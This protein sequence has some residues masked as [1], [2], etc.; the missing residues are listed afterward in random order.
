MPGKRIG[1][2]VVAVVAFAACAPSSTPGGYVLAVYEKE[3][4]TATGEAIARFYEN[5]SGTPPAIDPWAVFAVGS[6]G[7]LSTAETSWSYTAT[8]LGSAIHL[9][10]GNDTITMS[11]TSSGGVEEYSS[12]SIDG[13]TLAPG[14]SWDVE[15]ADPSGTGT[16]VWSGSLVMPS[17]PA[18]S[19]PDGMTAGKVMLPASGALTIAFPAAGAAEAY[20]VFSSDE[21]ERVCRLSPEAG[22]FSVPED[23]LLRL[24]RTGTMEIVLVNVTHETLSGNDIDVQGE[25]HLRAAF[26]RFGV[27]PMDGGDLQS[28]QQSTPPSSEFPTGAPL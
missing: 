25:V 11:L 21:G 4:S 14:E 13:A 6:C 20:V 18:V 23:E 17:V 3:G 24:P 5:V 26:T 16:D 2:C 12:G 10:R 15:F 22:S 8:D 1:L 19:E 28:R 7:A 27:S 9:Q